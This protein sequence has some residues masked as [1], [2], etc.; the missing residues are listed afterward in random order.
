MSTTVAVMQ[1]YF[2]PYAGYFRLFSAADVVVLFDCVQ[3]PRRGWVHRNVLPDA[4]GNAAW[5]TLPV[6][7]AP[8][9]ARICEMAFA[10][11]AAERI[12]SAMKRFPVLENPPLQDDA[13]LARVRTPHKDLTG[14][15]AESIDTVCERLRI[16]TTVLR[17]SAMNVP[18]SLRGQERVVEIARTL[19]ATRYVNPPGG[20]GLYDSALF[21]KHGIELR[22]LS[23]Y[24]GEKTSML[25]RLLTTPASVLS[26]EIRRQAA[27]V[28]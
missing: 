3:F 5:F 16:R 18:A 13:M 10:A 11:D 15:L 23:E 20:R 26:E 12:D 1:P 8:V 19:G 27:P 22:F 4:S 7:K 28:V 14:Y 24:A 25:A 9:D 17:S 6:A 2:M 21:E